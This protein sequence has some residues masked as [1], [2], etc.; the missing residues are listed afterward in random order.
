MALGRPRRARTFGTDC[1]AS[2]HRSIHLSSIILFVIFVVVVAVI[3][4]LPSP[5][6]IIFAGSDLPP[7]LQPPCSLTSE[8][9][10]VR[11]TATAQAGRDAHSPPR[12]RIEYEPESDAGKPE[13][14]R[15]KVESMYSLV[16]GL[17]GVVRINFCPMNRKVAFTGEW[18]KEHF[19]ALLYTPLA[20][21]DLK[22]WK[23]VA[24]LAITSRTCCRW[25]VGSMVCTSA[26]NFFGSVVC[27]S[28]LGCDEVWWGTGIGRGRRSRGRLRERLALGRRTDGRCF[29]EEDDDVKNFKVGRRSG[30]RRAG[31]G[32]NEEESRRCDNGGPIDDEVQTRARAVFYLSALAQTSPPPR[33]ILFAAP[34]Q[35]P[36]VVTS[37]LRSRDRTGCERPRMAVRWRG[38][39]RRGPTG[40]TCPSQ[41]CRMNN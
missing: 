38:Q 7:S 8:L 9:G 29:D 37:E 18:K 30:G 24:S 12:N 16:L 6:N 27:Q 31:G 23:G 36:V 20:A 14:F 26:S 28:A 3:A 4:A 35:N 1:S 32:R 39:Q 10:L 41:A 34:R 33:P 17:S 19:M 15:C 13:E 2:I 11:S 40:L 5:S 25:S 21:H 22:R